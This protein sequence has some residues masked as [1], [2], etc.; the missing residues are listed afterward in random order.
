MRG[1]GQALQEAFSGL[2]WQRCHTEESL[3]VHFRRIATGQTPSGYRDQMH[4]V[5]DRVLEADS[6]EEAQTRLD[7]LRKHLEEKASSALE[8]LEDGFYDATRRR[9]LA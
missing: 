4:E 9:G 6:Q 5:L 3:G 8:T 2:I 1:L 7:D